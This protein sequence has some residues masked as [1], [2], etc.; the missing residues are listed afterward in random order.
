VQRFVDPTAELRK[1]ACACAILQ[2][3]YADAIIALMQHL[4]VI[5]IIIISVGGV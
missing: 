2:E 5:A 1:I 4:T 3:Q